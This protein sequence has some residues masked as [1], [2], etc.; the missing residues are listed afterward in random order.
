MDAAPGGPLGPLPSELDVWMAHQACPCPGAWPLPNSPSPCTSLSQPR[1]LQE[2]FLIAEQSRAHRPPEHTGAQDWAQRLLDCELISFSLAAR[3]PGRPRRS[4]AVCRETTASPPMC[5]LSEPRP[6]WAQAPV[7]PPSVP[8]PQA[9]GSAGMRSSR[10]PHRAHTF[11]QPGLCKARGVRFPSAC[12][13]GASQRWGPLGWGS[14]KNGARQTQQRC[15]D[16]PGRRRAPGAEE[17]T[18]GEQF[19]RASGVPCG[20]PSAQRPVPRGSQRGPRPAWHL[21][22]GDT[23]YNRVE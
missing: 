5:S 3:G 12:R 11:Q 13:S 10:H 23:Q 21:H 22:T 1:P 4:Q 14:S 17:E 8:S 18:T 16:T 7:A 6:P 2:L 15:C 19:H 20:S 9:L